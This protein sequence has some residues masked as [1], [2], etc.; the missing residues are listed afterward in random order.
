MS[1]F[2]VSLWHQI[3]LSL[4]LFVLIVLGYGFIR[5]S[6]WPA[7]SLVMSTALAAVTT[8]LILTIMGVRV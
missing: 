6:K 2:I 7:T 1:V 3:A 8:P 4:P 5:W